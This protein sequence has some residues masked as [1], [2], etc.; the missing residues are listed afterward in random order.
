MPLLFCSVLFTLTYYSRADLIA[1][2]CKKTE[3]PNLCISTLRSN[4]DSKTADVEGLVRIILKVTFARVNATLD[5]VNDLLKKTKDRGLKQSLVICASLYGDAV[6]YEI[7]RAI[8]SVGKDNFTA[9]TETTAI[10]DDADTC[11]DQ[12]GESPITAENNII[13]QLAIIALG[14]INRLG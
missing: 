13:I 11:E 9:R 7:P 4:P 2:T 6:N 5:R 10:V 14:I 3:Y 12:F 8:Q 1:D